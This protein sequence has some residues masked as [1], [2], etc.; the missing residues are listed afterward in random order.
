MGLREQQDLLARLYT[1]PEFRAAF[2]SDPSGI[3]R[4]AGLSPD[5]IIAISAISSSDIDVYSEALFRKRLN[6]AK[7]ILPIT[8]R[9]L[10]DGFNA[11][12]RAFSATFNATG[13][14]KH[15]D[16]ALEF[17]RYL[18]SNSDI[19][20]PAR[21][22]ARFEG[23]RLEF[24]RGNRWIL[25][26]TAKYATDATIPVRRSAIGLLIRLGGRIYRFGG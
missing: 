24:F 3:G 10:G 23:K 14:H 21:D 22:A 18:R 20:S 7:K 17:S 2:S 26:S 11:H 8:V 6:E 16:D 25:L 1:D 4:D 15:L 9:V 5:D 12:F 19:P 13:A